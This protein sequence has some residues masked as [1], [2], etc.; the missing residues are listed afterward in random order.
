MA[1]PSTFG[2]SASRKFLIR[3]LIAAVVIVAGLSYT[4]NR[5]RS[6]DTALLALKTKI[7]SLIKVVET[8]SDSKARQSMTSAGDNR[9]YVLVSLFNDTT[10]R[11]GCPTVQLRSSHSIKELIVYARQTY[12]TLP[13]DFEDIMDA[14][15]EYCLLTRL[16]A[17]A[18]TAKNGMKA[19][20]PSVVVPADQPIQLVIEELQEPTK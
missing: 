3:F 9:Q 18:R 5:I 14:T 20:V 15:R 2:G 10:A 7:D 13:K 19:M 6:S 1:Q 8:K 17:P 11:L 16:Q 12:P 4:F